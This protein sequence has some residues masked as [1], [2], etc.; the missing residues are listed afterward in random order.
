MLCHILEKDVQS[1]AHGLVRHVLN[2][3]GE[4][5]GRILLVRSQGALKLGDF[6]FRMTSISIFGSDGFLA[7]CGVAQPNRKLTAKARP[8]RTHGTAFFMGLMG[9]PPYEWDTLMNIA[10][11]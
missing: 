4:D 8:T 11:G 10:W 1:I 6:G 7:G 3:H 5:Q 9:K 2:L